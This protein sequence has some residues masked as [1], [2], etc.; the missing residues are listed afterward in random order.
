VTLK[1][2][3]ST[4]TTTTTK[5]APTRKPRF[6]RQPKKKLGEL[7]EIVLGACCEAELCDEN[8]QD[9]CAACS[10][11]YSTTRRK[12]QERVKAKLAS[13]GFQ[14]IRW[15]MAPVGEDDGHIAVVRRIL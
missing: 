11:C 1:Q 10:S 8:P 2:S 14:W 6:A 3:T 9:G 15:K 12:Q 7:E 13:Q 4:S 5:T